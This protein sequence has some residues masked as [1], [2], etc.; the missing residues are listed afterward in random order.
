MESR[1]EEEVEYSSKGTGSTQ[2]PPPANT[3]DQDAGR[4]RKQQEDLSSLGLSKSKDVPQ[5]QSTSKK[6]PASLYD[7]LESDS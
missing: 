3:I 6:P 4:K 2:S 5:D 1:G 7:F